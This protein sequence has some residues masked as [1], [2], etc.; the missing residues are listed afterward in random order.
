[1]ENIGVYT[2][3]YYSYIIDIPSSPEKDALC[4][5]LFRFSL[6]YLRVIGKYA[7]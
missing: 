7:G 4:N 2:A 5:A 1:M 3:I 6:H